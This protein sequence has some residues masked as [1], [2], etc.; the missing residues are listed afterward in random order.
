M[1]DKIKVKRKRGVRA[2]KFDPESIYT[3]NRIR[4]HYQV[5]KKIISVEEFNILM[6]KNLEDFQNSKKNKSL[7]EYTNKN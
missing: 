4:Y 2:T 7:N 5:H 6:D 1:T 3:R